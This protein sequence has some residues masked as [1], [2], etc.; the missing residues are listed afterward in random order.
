MKGFVSYSIL[1]QFNT[2][3]DSTSSPCSRAAKQWRF[4]IQLEVILL[5]LMLLPLLLLLLLLLFSI[6]S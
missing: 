4:W 3:T 5:W 6:K 2:K 1:I